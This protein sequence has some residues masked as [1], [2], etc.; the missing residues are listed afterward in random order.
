MP[1]PA[2]R[3][4]LAAALAAAT[5][6][7]GLCATPT[8]HEALEAI[9]TL[10][11]SVAGPEAQAAARTIVTYAQ[12]SDDV[13][14]DIGPEEIPWAEEDWGIG[15]GR[16]KSC[17]SVLLAAFVAGDVRS[18]IKNNRVEDDTYSG[19]IFVISAYNRLRQREH[20][21]SPSIEALLKMQTSGTL[22]EHA[23]EVE[24]RAGQDEEPPEKKPMA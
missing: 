7:G 23:R 14:V 12:M 21:S 4:L 3:H 5:A 1:M 24:A 15:G 22:L 19:W 11:K 17:K 13:L 10:E 6:A 18:Q 20:F 2:M 16:E 9:A 8:Q